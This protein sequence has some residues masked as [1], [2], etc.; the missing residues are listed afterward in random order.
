MNCRNLALCPFQLCL[1]T[2]PANT[3]RTSFFSLNDSKR[4]FHGVATFCKDA[5][6]AP[7]A[8]ED[9]L[10][11]TRLQAAASA[12]R[13]IC[14]EPDSTWWW[15]CV[16][17]VALAAFCFLLSWEAGVWAADSCIQEQQGL[18]GFI[19][20]QTLQYKVCM[21]PCANHSSACAG[22]LIIIFNNQAHAGTPRLS[23]R[24]WTTRGAAS[25]PTTAGSCFSISTCRP[26][27]ARGRPTR[28][29]TATSTS[30]ACSRRAPAADWPTHAVL[31]VHLFSNKGTSQDK[32]LWRGAHC[33]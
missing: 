2:P 32:Q 29:G 5:T 24:R 1:P 11:G 28:P 3:C 30:C 26:P 31:N 19:S 27:R 15:R 21:A 9:G 18:A 8:V 4:P 25:S 6:A 13:G 17:G 7:V 20:A 14:L 16:R 33:G 12:G 22:V 10:A 23:W